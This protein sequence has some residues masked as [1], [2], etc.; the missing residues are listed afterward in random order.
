[1]EIK[2]LAEIMDVVDQ[3]EALKAKIDE[4]QSGLPSYAKAKT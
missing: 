2:P 4:L 1:V 3:V